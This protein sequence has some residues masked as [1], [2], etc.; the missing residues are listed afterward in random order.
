MSNP[1]NDLCI[2]RV[3]C[4]DFLKEPCSKEKYE[5][6]KKRYNDV[7]DKSAIRYYKEKY[8]ELTRAYTQLQVSYTELLNKK[9]DK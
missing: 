6:C 9:G 2:Y 4:C 8:D 3:S 1:V 5:A 7:V